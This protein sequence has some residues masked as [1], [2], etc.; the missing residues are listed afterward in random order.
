MIDFPA[1]PTTG[2][3][4][5]APTGITYRW[6]GTLWI[7]TGGSTGGDFFAS[8][9][10]TVGS[11]PI[12]PT[13]LVVRS[14]NALIGGVA[15]FN[16][17][18][19]RFTPPAGRYYL[20]A[21]ING[22]HSAALNFFV[23]L[24]KNGVDLEG[25]ASTIPTANYWGTS[26]VAVTYDANGTDWFDAQ[27]WTTG[28]AS[29]GIGWLWFGAFPISGI[30]GPPGPPGSIPTGDFF[31]TLSGFTVLAAGAV[32]TGYTVAVGNTGSWLNTSTGRYTPPAGRYKIFAQYSAT[33]NQASHCTLAIRKNGAT[34][35]YN[36]STIASATYYANPMAE[37]VVDANGTDYFDVFVS[38]NANANG[39]N[40]GFG[41]FP[42]SGT[43]GPQGDPGPAAPNA[44]VLYSEKVCVGGET[45]MD[46]AMPANPK[47]IE[48]HYSIYE[49]AGADQNLGMRVIRNGVPDGGAN[50][51]HQAMY[52]S[53]T[54]VGA[55]GVNSLTSWGM[56]G[57]RY[58]NGIMTFVANP[59]SG[60]FG[61]HNQALISGAARYFQNFAYDGPA[62]TPAGGG[63]RLLF[64]GAGT[65]LAGSFLRAYVVT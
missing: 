31:A 56:S 13:N 27:M 65:F 42:I 32:V 47:R 61:V 11:T 22:S 1:S 40:F 12:T 43:K 8:V 21:A 4:F 17:A 41:A 14:G 34:V 28:V 16:A 2:Q 64:T 19:G 7:A 18:T 3:I 37:A 9:Q 39:Q 6:T 29:S 38:A 15:P 58:A 53:G 45:F 23:K 33:Q 35:Q 55:S 52:G 10:T 48:L 36:T 62:L 59:N 46:V 20:W 60:L 24:R 44:L 26:T 49:A 50:Y 25:S 57:G 63:F 54:A 30:Q 5:N 51:S